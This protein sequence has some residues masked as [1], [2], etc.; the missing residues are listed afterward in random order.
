[1][2]ELVK[3]MRTGFQMPV[4]IYPAGALSPVISQATVEVHYGKHL[5]TYV[6]NLNKFVAD[7]EFEGMTLREIIS[8]APPGPLLDNAGQVLN[9]SLYFEQF[10]PYPHGSNLPVM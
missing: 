7:T 4:L 1:M 10:T 9:H 5:Q 3:T 6:D 2:S 8:Q